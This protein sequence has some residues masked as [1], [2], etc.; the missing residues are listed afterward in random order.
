MRA[1]VLVVLVLAS[2]RGNDHPPA[3]APSPV[4][5][6]GAPACGQSG[7]PD[8][9]ITQEQCSCLGGQVRGDLGDGQIRCQ[10]GERELGRVRTGIEGGVCCASA[11]SASL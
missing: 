8:A 1:L 2:C 3:S 11:T 9:P 5:R 4:E 7:D 6:P 10:D